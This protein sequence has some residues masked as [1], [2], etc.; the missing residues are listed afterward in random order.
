MGSLPP[1]SPSKL[2]PR[3][4]DTGFPSSFDGQR[5]TT[6]PHP[7]ADLSPNASISA[8]DIAIGRVLSRQRRSFLAKHRRTV[9]HGIITPEMERTHSG[10]LV[11][12]REENEPLSTVN[13][14]HSQQ[15]RSSNHDGA[16]FA[17][18]NESGVRVQATPDMSPTSDRSFEAP[19]DPSPNGHKRRRSLLKRL[20]HR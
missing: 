18:S 6:L 19:H 15:S 13:T 12:L 17:S 9:S 1:P 5:N 8:D 14:K 10:N 16:S 11:L 3:S 20:M 7:D 2:R 4:R